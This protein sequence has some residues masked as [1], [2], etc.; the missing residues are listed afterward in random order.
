M[1]NGDGS[2]Q[3]SGNYNQNE[4]QAK[5]NVEAFNNPFTEEFLKSTEPVR[6]GYYP[7]EGKSGAFTMDFPEDMVMNDTGYSKD[8]NDGSEVIIFYHPDNERDLVW[9]I[10]IEYMHLW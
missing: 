9:S 8:P 10:I 6:E 5:P 1:S 4:A 3:S 2:D 7:L